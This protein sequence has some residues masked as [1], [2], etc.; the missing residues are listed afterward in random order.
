MSNRLK[1]AAM[2][3]VPLIVAFAAA[4]LIRPARTNPATNASQKIEAQGGVSRAFVAVLN[5]ACSD[6]H[7][8]KTV[9]SRYTRVAPMSWLVVYSV[10]EGRR[11][12]NFS[13]WAEY[14][15]EQRRDFLIESCQD[16]TSGKMPSGLY[17]ML[18]PEARLSARD[19]E[20]I[21]AAARQ[22]HE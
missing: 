17:T 10:A 8:N 13:Q 14:S 7:S 5:R 19:V 15:P 16:A 1:M 4:Q 12:V 22:L 6:C 20:T 9:W 18:Y 11:A 3:L 2:V 21:C